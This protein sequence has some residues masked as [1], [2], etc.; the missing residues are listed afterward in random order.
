VS[1]G[2]SRRDRRDAELTR[3]VARRAIRR[4]DILESVMIAGAA[5][6]A[7]AG[8][9]GIA[10]LLAALGGLAFGR[11]WIVS[12]LVLFVVPGA[13]AIFIIRRDQREVARR[14]AGQHRA[15]RNGEGKE[16]DV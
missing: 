11:T 3:E 4:L 7:L 5:A 8:G 15:D 2:Q 12:S 13:V 10:W 16:D 9:A 14:V 6:L 1:P